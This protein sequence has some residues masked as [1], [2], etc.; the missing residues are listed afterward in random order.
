[1]PLGSAPVP[2]DHRHLRS[3]RRLDDALD[4][5]VESIEHGEPVLAGRPEP[6]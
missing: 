5:T 3:G 2:D 4:E 6:V 1:M